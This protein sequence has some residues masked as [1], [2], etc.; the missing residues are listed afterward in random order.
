MDLQLKQ[1]RNQH[2]SEQQLHSPNMP[3]FL[4]QHPPPPASAAL[5]LFLPQ[6]NTVVSTLPRFFDSS[7]P[8]A[9][10]RFPRMESCFSF[11]QWQE[12]ELQGLIFRYMLAGAPVPPQLLQ[13]IKKT[14]LE[15]GYY[16]GR[17]AV[18][19]EPGRCRRTDGKKWRCSREAVEGQKYCERHMHRGRNRS[20]KPVE[21]PRASSSSPSSFENHN[22][23]LHQSSSG[24]KGDNKRLSE[25]LDHV[26]GDD[27][28]GGHV[29]RHFFDDWP[30]TQEEPDRGETNGSQNNNAET[31]LSMSTPG[32]TS[33]DVSLKLSA[34]HAQD[35]CHVASLGGPLAE[36]LRSSTSSSSPT[37]VL[38][39]LPTSSAC[40]TSFI[41]I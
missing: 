1:W 2:E 26:D 38:L 7:L 39:Q 5:P 22:L 35:T 16:W 8:S 21:Q 31:C 11:A 40:E 15:S 9:P 41:S 6:P 10:P 33:S 28:S 19:P 36:A 24:R 25:N 18:D 29:L 37:S 14:V 17:E 4:P 27:R 32:I 12:L 13:P 34:G 3:K 20:R 30:K 23:H